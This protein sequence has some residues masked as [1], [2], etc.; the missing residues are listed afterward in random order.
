MKFN[1]SG[2]KAKCSGDL[3]CPSGYPS[4]I[5][6][7]SMP[8]GSSFPLTVPWGHLAL[9]PHLYN[10]YTLSRGLFSSFTCEACSISLWV[11]FWVTLMLVTSS[12]IC[13][14]RWGWSHP[15]HHRPSNLHSWP[16][17]QRVDTLTN[18]L[19]PDLGVME[20]ERKESAEDL[21][22]ER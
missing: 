7:F 16:L 1:P 3:S 22:R 15:T 5:V 4:V 14:L 11:V 10:S 21:E 17:I 20:T 2:F 13:G 19:S 9:L 8:A 18:F 6:F 12:C